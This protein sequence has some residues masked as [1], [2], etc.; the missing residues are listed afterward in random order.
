[1]TKPP[2]II[3]AILIDCQERF[4]IDNADACE[5]EM[6]SRQ[7]FG[8]CKYYVARQPAGGRDDVVRAVVLACQARIDFTDAAAAEL[9][10]SAR[11]KYGSRYQY[12]GSAKGLDFLTPDLIEQRRQNGERPGDIADHYGIHRRTIYNIL[13]RGRKNE[14]SA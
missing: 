4:G 10:K 1:M 14:R 2:D 5:I 9:E 13:R 6:H 7:A 11:Q 8:G 12:V 3:A